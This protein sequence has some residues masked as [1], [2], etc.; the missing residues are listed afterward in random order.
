[1]KFGRFY[2]GEAEIIGDEK[3]KIIFQN[4]YLAVENQSE[5]VSVPDIITLVDSFTLRPITTE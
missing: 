2:G 3:T 1:M 4:E 5:K